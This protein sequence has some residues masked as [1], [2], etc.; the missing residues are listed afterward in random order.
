M[1]SL[2]LK[3]KVNIRI[4][5]HDEMGRKIRKLVKEIINTKGIVHIPNFE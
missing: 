5:C 3:F 2:E 1:M 4:D